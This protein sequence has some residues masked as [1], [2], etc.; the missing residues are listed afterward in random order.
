[1]FA[2][3]KKESEK[4]F[5]KFKTIFF[6][7]LPRFPVQ[8]MLKMLSSCFSLFSFFFF[9]FNRFFYYLNVT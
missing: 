3:R 7:A 1:M 9:F 4:Q 6:K 5:I 2:N 8:N